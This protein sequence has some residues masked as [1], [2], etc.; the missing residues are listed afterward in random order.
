MSLPG[1]IKLPM[2]LYL[3]S[4]FSVCTSLT[5]S[6]KPRTGV[7]DKVVAALHSGTWKNATLGMLKYPGFTENSGVSE[8]LF[9]DDVKRFY[10][11]EDDYVFL[12]GNMQL[13]RKVGK[14]KFKKVVTLPNEESLISVFVRVNEC[15][16][17]KQCAA[18]NCEFSLQNCFSR[19]TCLKHPYEPLENKSC[20]CQIAFVCPVEKQDRR[21]WVISFSDDEGRLHS[22][23]RPPENR[24]VS[25]VRSDIVGAVARDPTLTVSEI[26][27]GVGVGYI[28]GERNLAAVNLDRVRKV[29][30]AV[31][32]GP[33]TL[34][35]FLETFNEAVLKSIP[36][37]QHDDE[38]INFEMQQA[39]QKYLRFF[40][41]DPGNSVCLIMFEIQI[42][43]L[44]KADFLIPDVTYPGTF[45]P[46]KYLLNVVVYDSEILQYV[47]VARVLMSN[48][49]RGSY[50]RAFGAL[51]DEVQKKH[52][53]Y[54]PVNLIVIADFSESQKQGLESAVEERS[55]NNAN[56]NIQQTLIRIRGCR[57]HFWRSVNKISQKIC[58]AEDEVFEFKSVARL[59]ES[60]ANK[61]QADLCFSVLSGKPDQKLL[62]NFPGLISDAAL[63]FCNGWSQAVSWVSFWSRANNLKMICKSLSEFTD[64]EWDV[65]PQT[66]NAVESH[67]RLSKPTCKTI[68]AALKWYYRVDRTSAVKIVAARHGVGLNYPSKRCRKPCKLSNPSDWS[69][70]VSDQ[71]FSFTESTFGDDE[72]VGSFIMVNTVGAKGKH[73]GKLLAKVVERT[74]DGYRAMYHDTPSYETY[75]D[76][77]ND[78]D[79][80]LLPKSFEPPPPVKKKH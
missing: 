34:P 51:F 71:N 59:L 60:A 44:A 75:V 15:A 56:D 3:K 29:V 46:F 36:L 20:H 49:H 40:S 5:S 79:V 27:K 76:G 22:H 25:R 57:V 41:L 45:H 17:V 7:A 16:G 42:D 30:D 18:A 24:L 9:V 77:P 33:E 1:V 52:P 47:T 13:T 63:R 55:I 64:K 50:K 70:E 37:N 58:G 31:R 69:E 73:Y 67:N 38:Q 61:Q 4:A 74:E 32:K 26:H 66:T 28:L 78:P 80:I 48:L 35:R 53:D 2:V 14:P 6:R 43:V 65:L 39:T 21:R 54:C 19:N 72:F 12:M 8:V 62:K 10:D 23:A 11:G 68:A